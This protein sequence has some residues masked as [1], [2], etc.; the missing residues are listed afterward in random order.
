[1]DALAAEIAVDEEHGLSE[2]AG[3]GEGE[4]DG[5]RGLAFAG[6]GACDHDGLAAVCSVFCM[7]WVRSTLYAST[8][9]E[10][11]KHGHAPVCR[12]DQGVEG[13]GPG[14]RVAGG[15]PACFF[16][17]GGIPRL[18]GCR[19]R[20]HFLPWSS[21]FRVSSLTGSKKLRTCRRLPSPMFFER[22]N[23]SRWLSLA[24]STSRSITKK[25]K[26]T[27][28]IATMARPTAMA[29]LL[30]AVRVW[31]PVAPR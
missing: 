25:W 3:K 14:L 5:A 8:S 11:G 1:M 2:L 21:S 15:N 10:L 29:I 18:L 6:K 16:L 24:Q 26:R 19:A 28:A 27:M 12:R 22:Y 17:S 9:G 30:C 31:P 13:Y 20:Q 23:I 7:I 4:V